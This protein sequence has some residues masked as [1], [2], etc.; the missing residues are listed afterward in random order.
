MTGADESSLMLIDGIEFAVFNGEN[1]LPAPEEVYP[2]TVSVV[3]VSLDNSGRTWTGEEA[4]TFHTC[5]TDEVA[6][7]AI[8]SI[9]AVAH[10]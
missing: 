9:T 7:W 8:E 6:S 3:V 1:I 4:F 5:T 2:E 10:V